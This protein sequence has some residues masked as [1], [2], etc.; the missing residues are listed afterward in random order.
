MSQMRSS[1][2][3]S[4]SVVEEI[5]AKKLGTWSTM[6]HPVLLLSREV[7]QMEGMECEEWSVCVCVSEC[8][9]LSCERLYSVVPFVC[10]FSSPALGRRSEIIEVGGG[11]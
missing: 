9:L 6:A 3:S 4:A 2:S 11:W 8:S 7:R 1:S 5:L 10:L